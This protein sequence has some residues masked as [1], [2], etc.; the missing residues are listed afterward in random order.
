MDYRPAF[1]DQA[2]SFFA[3]L[4]RRRQ[5]QLLERSRELAAF[6]NVKPDYW[7]EDS[8]GRDIANLMVGGFLFAYWVDHAVKTVMIVEIDDAE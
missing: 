8:D 5:R 3:S 1:S 6:P 7:S 2:V 4:P